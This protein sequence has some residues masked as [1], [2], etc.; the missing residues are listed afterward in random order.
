MGC[1]DAKKTTSASSPSAAKYPLALA[2][3]IGPEAV[4]LRTPILI[5]SACA[6]VES[7]RHARK[8]KILIRSPIQRGYEKH[9]SVNFVP[10]PVNHGGFH[11]LARSR[12]DLGNAPA[13]TGNSSLGAL[14][15]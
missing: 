6:T 11:L 2:I 13:S 8:N 1:A 3:K 10:P 5:C 7:T 12:R 4:V 14:E 9:S 15:I